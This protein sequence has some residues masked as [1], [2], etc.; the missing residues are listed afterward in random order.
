[1]EQCWP[2]PPLCSFPGEGS[3]NVRGFIII[4]I[5][6]FCSKIVTVELLIKYSLPKKIMKQE[7]RS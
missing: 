6:G 2:P 1:V 7:F 5:A 4:I 3:T